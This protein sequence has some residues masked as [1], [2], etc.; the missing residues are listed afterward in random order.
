VLSSASG[1]VVYSEHNQYQGKKVSP[2]AAVQALEKFSFAKLVEH[3][4]RYTVRVHDRCWF[5]LVHGAD[6]PSA[7]EGY[8]CSW[9]DTDNLANATKCAGCGEPRGSHPNDPERKPAAQ[10]IRK[11]LNGK[12]HLSGGLSA[13]N[14]SSGNR[15]MR[16]EGRVPAKA[17]AT[18]PRDYFCKKC[19]G[20]DPYSTVTRMTKAGY[21]E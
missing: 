4:G 6:L 7:D 8:N 21:L 15:G 11:S 9:C 3:D 18:F 12:L 2:E 16:L 13:A 1:C 5:E 10:K 19:F 17:A 20:S 14:C